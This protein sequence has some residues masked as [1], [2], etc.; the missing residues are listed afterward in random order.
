MADGSSVFMRVFFLPRQRLQQQQ[1]RFFVC[2]RL[3]SACGSRSVQ[4]AA[5][6]HTG[7]VLMSSFIHLFIYFLLASLHPTLTVFSPLCSLP[8]TPLHSPRFISTE[9][10]EQPVEVINTLVQF[11]AVQRKAADTC[12]VLIGLVITFTRACR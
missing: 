8:P 9:R 10:C 5:A 2:G 4:S 11:A 3:L 1:Q 6:P 12:H 7:C